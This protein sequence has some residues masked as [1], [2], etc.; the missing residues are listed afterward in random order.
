[1]STDTT[2]SCLHNVDFSEFKIDIIDTPGLADTRG[3]EQNKENI[4]NIIGALKMAD[5]VNCVCLVINGT[6]S[7][8]TS[9]MMMAMREIKHT[10]SPE[11]IDNFIVVLTK[12]N[13]AFNACFEV[14]SLEEFG[15][16]I[17]S[18]HIFTFDNPYARW[19]KTKNMSWTRLPSLV[20]SEFEAA[21][22]TLEEML[23]VIK[24]LKPIK[25]LKFGVLHEMVDKIKKCLPDLIKLYE[26][27]VKVE[28]KEGKLARKSSKVSSSQNREVELTPG[29]KN[30][31]CRYCTLNCHAPCSCKLATL[32]TGM[33]RCFKNLVCR[34]CGHRYSDH[35][36]EEYIY[37]IGA[38][39]TALSND[40]VKQL[41]T[42]NGKIESREKVLLKYLVSL[43][44]VAKN[45]SCAKDAIELVEDLRKE[46]QRISVFIDDKDI[47][48]RLSKTIEQQMESERKE[49][50]K[51]SEKKEKEKESEKKEQEKESSE[52]KEQDEEL[53]RNIQ[54]KLE[55]EEQE[56]EFESGKKKKN[57]KGK[58]KQDLKDRK[59]RNRKGKNNRRK[60]KKRN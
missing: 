28:E 44:E 8:S 35:T 54:E 34:E 53:R 60:R 9:V 3:E 5:Y 41:Q 7:R 21:F 30:V 52:G 31:I 15:L 16:S 22:E 20:K 36:K 17:K 49:K 13:D 4:A 26:N 11:V 51:E 2:T 10:L 29:S 46:I 59:R 56:E 14:S 38:D 1:M 39:E 55:R 32:V 50:E 18:E 58:G 47:V 37:K 33:C 42:I 43:K 23:S 25:T 57:Q 24:P 40:P 19:E 27:R 6:Q 48:K 45:Y 12:V